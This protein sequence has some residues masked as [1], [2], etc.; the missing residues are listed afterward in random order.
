[1]LEILDLRWFN[2]DELT[3]SLDDADLPVPRFASIGIGSSLVPSPTVS[4]C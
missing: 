4:E 3:S 1:M 2:R